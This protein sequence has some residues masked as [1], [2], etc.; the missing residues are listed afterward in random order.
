MEGEIDN[1]GCW[2][3]LDHWTPLWFKEDE[4]CVKMSKNNL[5]SVTVWELVNACCQSLEK[6]GILSNSLA[7]KRGLSIGKWPILHL[8]PG[9]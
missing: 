3:R 1:T 7:R 4:R 2:L 6:F 9:W 5:L 8:V